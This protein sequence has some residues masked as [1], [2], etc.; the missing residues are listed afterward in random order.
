MAGGQMLRCGARLNADAVAIDHDPDHR[1]PKRV[2]RACRQ[3]QV[4]QEL[5]RVVGVIG[6]VEVRIRS[7]AFDALTLPDS[8]A[9]TAADSRGLSACAAED[10]FTPKILAGLIDGR[11]AA[12]P[13][14][15]SAGAASALIAALTDA[16]G[17]KMDSERRRSGLSP[18]TSHP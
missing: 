12:H 10:G 16:C 2:W 11:Y 18:L 5:R 1:G 3:P 15:W 6:A 9:E 13:E 8:S 4:R 7:G 17:T 14:E